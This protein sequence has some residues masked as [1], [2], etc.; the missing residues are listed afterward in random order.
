M[1]DSYDLERFVDAQQD[2]YE[3]ALAEIKAGRKRCHWM[4]YI[5]PQIEGL[6]FS[7]MSQR[8]AIRSAA[9]AKAYLSHPILGARLITSV[10]ALLD[11]QGR[12]VSEIFGFPD[13]VKL[14]SCATLFAAVSP[15]GS[16]FHRLLDK[17]F[18][19]EE[20]AATLKKLGGLPR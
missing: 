5:F 18:E 6:G 17:Y 9:E 10:E 12:T 20:D 19:G 14:R 13:D 8:F 1:N 11:L 16:V 4:W 3:R 15:T 2:V 7:V